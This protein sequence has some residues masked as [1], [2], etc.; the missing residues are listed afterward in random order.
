[1]LDGVER[2]S[3]GYKLQTLMVTGSTHERQ[4]LTT[5]TQV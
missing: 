2:T 1:M 3:Q 5:Y 4:V